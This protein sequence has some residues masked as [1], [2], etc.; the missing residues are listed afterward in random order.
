MFEIKDKPK[1]P[2]I[3]ASQI[4]NWLNGVVTAVDDGRTPVEG[5]RSTVNTIL[6]EDGVIKQRPSLKLWGPQPTGEILGELFQYRSLSGL[7][8][9][10]RLISMQ[11]ITRNEI[12]TLSIT[13]APTGGTFTITYDGQTT[14]NL[15]FDSTAAEVETALEALSNID[16]VTCTGG[17]LPAD[18]VYVEFAG[19]LAETDVALMTTTDSL[20]GGSTPATDIVETKKGGDSVGRIF[21]ALP[22]DSS[23]TVVTSPT[24]DDYDGTAKAHFNQL[25]RKVLILNSENE[26]SYYDIV[27]DEIIKFT[28]LANPSAPTLDTNTGLDSNTDFN[29]YYAVTANSTVGETTGTKLKV[30]VD[31]PRDLWDEETE[32]IKIAWTTVTGV[33]SWNVYCAV[34]A[35]G[36]ENPTWGLIASNISADTLEFT[37]TGVNGT[38]AIN[39]F[40]PLPTQNSTAGPKATRCEVINGRLWLT[41]DKN[42]PYYIWYGGDF[43]HELDFTPANGG[44]FAQVGSGSRELPVK[45]WNFRTGPGEPII[46]A[47][48]RG[49][50]GQGKR[51][52]LSA[53]TI[54]YGGTSI[55]YWSAQEDYGYSGTDSPDAL[56]IYGNNAYYPSRDGFKTVGTKPQLQNLLSIDGIT[57]TILP[58]LDFLNQD[59]ME[60]AV[61]VGFENRL[62]FALPVGS[63]S[64]NQIWVIDL[65]RKG[66]WMKPWVISA[67]W[68]AVVADN[69]GKSHLLVVDGSSVYK[70]DENIKTSDNGE[71][72][73]TGGTSGFNRFS[74]SGQEWARLIKVIITVLRP[75]GRINFQI[76]GFTNKGRVER[77]GTGELNESSESTSAGWS[78]A[79]WDGFIAAGDT[80]W[81]NFYYTADISPS[82]QKEVTIKINKDVQYWAYS[83]NTQ[84]AGVNYGISRIVPATVDVGIKNL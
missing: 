61:G 36:D 55:V 77:L 41:G 74:E 59:A 2:K 1:P 50:N 25:D 40:R 35:D 80:G 13:G 14:G 49:L 10:N 31:S 63:D 53:S 72:F 38:G 23:W 62:Y 79:G 39:F 3:K 64:N 81:S 51:Y 5:L 82:A 73:V 30:Q 42:N 47:L 18:D 44:G 21:K 29:V 71:A 15:D 46:K 52:S 12:Q 22:E 19:T 48:T 75:K 58:D 67:D 32:S 65:Q 70:F 37:D 20:T 76:D 57:D 7:S 83:W 45:V 24:T 43:G 4:D 78:E 8:T 6:D 16:A 60:D 9:T 28:A 68:M 26:L 17:P 84:E 33:V 27:D 11:K 69:S 54:S 34:T 66:A 56:I